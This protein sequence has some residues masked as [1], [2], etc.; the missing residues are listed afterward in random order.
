MT[1]TVI[2]GSGN[3]RSLKT[4]PT[5]LTLYPTYEDMIAA[6]VNGTFPIDLGPLNAAGVQT[7]GDAL[8][9]ASLLTDA[10]CSALGLSTTATPTQAMAKLRQL[11]ATAQSTASAA[12]STANGKARVLW[13]SYT[14]TGD[15]ININ[16]SI[17]P[18]IVFVTYGGDSSLGLP[19]LFAV[20]TDRLYSGLTISLSIMSGSTGSYGIRT[21]DMAMTVNGVQVKGWLSYSGRVYEYVAVYEH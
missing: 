16:L 18:R 14:G 7:S 11:T 19:M 15:Y 17:S 6:M 21:G 13:G 12:Q 5:A 10:L 3:S 2:K 8:N 20:N 4:I 1:D 9:K